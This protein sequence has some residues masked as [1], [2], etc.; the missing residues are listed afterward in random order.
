MHIQ[1][2]TA[3]I[4]GGQL[5]KVFIQYHDALG[6]T[7]GIV[8]TIIGY[9]GIALTDALIV[10]KVIQTQRSGVEVIEGAKVFFHGDIHGFFIGLVKGA[11]QFCT[12]IDVQIRQRTGHIQHTIIAGN[13][14]DRTLT[15][16]I[17]IVGEDVCTTRV[18]LHTHLGG[19]NAH[20][21]DAD[22]CGGIS[23][24]QN[25]HTIVGVQVVGIDAAVYLGYL[26]LPIVI[27]GEVVAAINA[28]G[29]QP[30]GIGGVGDIKDV[31]AVALTEFQLGKTVFNFGGRAGVFCDTSFMLA[32]GG[33][34]IGLSVY[35]QHCHAV[36]LTL[37]M[38]TA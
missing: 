15:A 33:I 21:T 34:Q 7:G 25:V 13:G 35:G 36:A 8:A 1:S 2:H 20:M 10:G 37:D 27:V 32:C 38:G 5:L 23:H 12:G 4:E 26:Y 9:Y 19:G 11:A 17:L 29:G 30:N 14:G 6:T 16:Q 3:Y 31:Q 18:G 24:I 28:A 22:G